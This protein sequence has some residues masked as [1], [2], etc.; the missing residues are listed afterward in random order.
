MYLKMS[1]LSLA[2]IAPSTKSYLGNASSASIAQSLVNL[3]GAPTYKIGITGDYPPFDYVSADG[4]PAGF[5]VA[6]LNAISEKAGIN[7]Q[8]IQ[9]EAPARITALNSGEIDVVFWMGY[10]KFDGYEPVAKGLQLTDA[11]HSERM[12]AVAKS[13][14]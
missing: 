3:E 2:N 1:A 13:D 4:T 11:Y 9:V 8:I 12:V 6:I 7:F 14:K 5:N 10:S